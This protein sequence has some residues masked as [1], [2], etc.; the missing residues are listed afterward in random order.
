MNLIREREADCLPPLNRDGDNQ[1]NTDGERKMNKTF[2]QW[3]EE[4]ELSG[5]D[6]IHLVLFVLRDN[7]PELF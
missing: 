4:P 2:Q 3:K 7:T 5:L 6:N 1:K